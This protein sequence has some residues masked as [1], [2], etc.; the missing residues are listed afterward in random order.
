MKKLLLGLVTA[1]VVSM[2][3][4]GCGVLDD[5]DDYDDYGYEDYEEGQE[6]GDE[7]EDD[8]SGSSSNGD[9]SKWDDKAYGGRLGSAKELDG[10][11]VIVSI[12]ADDKNTTWDGDDTAK[13]NSLKYLGVATD[14]LT[15]SCGEYGANAKFIY[16]WEENPDLYTE[17]QFEYDM[18]KGEDEQYYAQMDYV[19]ANIDS[20]KIMKEY[21]ADNIIYMMYFNTPE[22]S[23]VTSA[24]YAYTNEETAD[25]PYEIVSIYVRC[26][27]E[28]ESPA[29]YAHEILHTFGAPDFYQ[30]DEDGQNYGITQD[31]VDYN[32]ENSSNDI[33]Y[34]TFDANSET[35]YYD[36]VSNDFTDMVA[37]Y[38]GLIPS[39]DDV[40][41]WGLG[42]SQH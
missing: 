28:E 12:Y 31:F 40:E 36:H 14:W 39:C 1:S 19:D 41:E 9:Y 38:V 18:T 16:D 3:F 26:D 8:Y 20:D 30:A 23:D 10:T 32:E 2:L 24:T 27:G 42:E 34:T 17:T 21:D 22:E 7:E 13:E 11:T 5:Y 35:P 6:D 4:T 29:S 33:M 15:K 37:Y 25:Y